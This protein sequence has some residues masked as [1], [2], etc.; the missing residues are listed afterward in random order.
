MNCLVTGAA[1]FIGSYL[2]RRLLDLGHDVIGVDCFTD[3]YARWI[4][5]QNVEPLVR[6]KNFRFRA[7]N[8]LDLDLGSLL[9]RVDVVFHL[10][11][12]AGVRTS[13]GDNFSVYIH[14]NVLA[15]QKLLEAAKT[16][17][18][19]RFIYASSSSVY[20]LTPKLPMSEDG[21]CRPVSPYGVTKL[22]AEQL[23]LLY[24]KNFEVPTLSLRFFTVYGPG[25]RPDMAFHRFF[26]SIAEGK[27]IV[28]F[29]D[30][31]QTRDF[32]YVEDIVAACLQAVERGRLGEAYNIG[33]GHREK[34][35]DLVPLFEEVCRRPVTVVWEEEQKGDVRHTFADI[36]RAIKELLYS[37]QT[38]LREGLS[39]EWKWIRHLYDL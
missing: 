26:K 30:G 21:L 2:C 38:D 15:T 10:A 17:P 33:G 16:K 22:A 7:E 25:Q 18:L 35:E 34:L 28:I 24:F 14:N 39:Q 23:C 5:Q 27:P 12:Q 11:A 36:T 19:Q 8:I 9:D 31:Q 37:P 4:K 29:G 3:F 20:G 13:W 1:G 32:T 6:R